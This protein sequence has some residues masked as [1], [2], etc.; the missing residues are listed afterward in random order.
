V[1]LPW[2]RPGRLGAASRYNVCYIQEVQ[3]VFFS[4]CS[5]HCR[6]TER[7]SDRATERPSDR[8]TDRATERAT[9]RP[10]DRA[11]ER[12]SDRAT[13]RPSDRA[14][15]RRVHATS[16]VEL[17]HHERREEVIESLNHLG[18]ARRLRIQNKCVG[19]AHLPHIICHV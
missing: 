15:E 10:S 4:A 7:P 1:E 9:E 2:P 17:V 13:E 11:T 6:T 14:T 3:C 19:A 12:P 8:A 5:G 18:R 16:H